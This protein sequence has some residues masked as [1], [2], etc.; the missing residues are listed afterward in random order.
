MNI[1]PDLTELSCPL[2]TSGGEEEEALHAAV[3]QCVIIFESQK[4]QQ[5]KPKTYFRGRANKKTP[6]LCCY[7]QQIFLFILIFSILAFIFNTLHRSH[8]S[9]F[10]FL[11]MNRVLLFYC[12][13]MMHIFFSIYSACCV[14]TRIMLCLL[15]KSESE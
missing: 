4:N 11:F 8:F 10:L 13:S 12:M 15:D 5:L 1:S 6:S 3:E 2:A 14:A 7:F 9:A